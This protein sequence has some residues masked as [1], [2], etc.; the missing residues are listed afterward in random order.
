ME[1]EAKLLLGPAMDFLNWRRKT[2]F[3]KIKIKKI[4]KYYCSGSKLIG[5][6]A[7]NLGAQLFW[8]SEI[9]SRN[10][11]CSCPLYGEKALWGGNLDL[12]SQGFWKKEELGI[13]LRKSPKAIQDLEFSFY[14]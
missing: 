5:L 4:A 10:R 14:Q 12:R 9:A 8:M 6:L 7:L 11:N 13:C 3:P 2:G 1:A